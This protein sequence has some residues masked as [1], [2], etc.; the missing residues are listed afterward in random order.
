MSGTH[1]YFLFMSASL[2]PRVPRCRCKCN[3]SPVCKPLTPGGNCHTVE[4]I[5]GNLPRQTRRMYAE[6]RGEKQR[7]AE[8]WRVVRDPWRRGNGPHHS[9]SWDRS[10]PIEC[11]SEPPEGHRVC[12]GPQGGIPLLLVG[13]DR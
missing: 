3:R 2:P 5:S 6:N 1:P 12:S 8:G 11:R 13:H 9:L 10:L 7:V 4:W